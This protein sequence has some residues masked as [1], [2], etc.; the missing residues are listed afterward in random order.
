MSVKRIVVSAVAIIFVGGIALFVHS[1]GLTTFRQMDRELLLGTPAGIIKVSKT[2]ATVA[3][4]EAAAGAL[5]YTEK[6]V[7]GAAGDP[8]VRVVIVERRNAAPGRPAIL[9]IHGGGFEYGSPEMSLT[10]LVEGLVLKLGITAVSVDYRLAPKTNY[11]GSLH[12]NQAALKWLHD[13]AKELGVDP[14]RIGIVGFSAGGTHAASMSIHN[15]GEGSVP[16]L[17]QALI[18]AALDDRTGS[19]IDPGESLGHFLWTREDNHEAWT[20]FLGADAGSDKIP[21]DAVPMRAVDL[22]GLPPTYIS[23]GSLDLFATENEAFAQKLK[24]SGVP[25]ELHVFAGAFHGS[26]LIVPSAKVSQ[27]S[28]EAL[29][30]YMA[31]QFG[32]AKPGP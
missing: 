23:V 25:V 20:K 30:G 27:Q 19:T 29:V 1:V 28:R 16:V 12:D 10:T 14:R 32:L 7:P 13:H 21:A 2:P 24:A 17:F 6:F 26:E 3:E 5:H 11:L 8:P 4:R 9:D 22:T 31:R 18:S 15:R